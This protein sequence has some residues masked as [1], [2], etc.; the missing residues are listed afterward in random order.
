MV[1]SILTFCGGLALFVYGVD[2]LSSAMRVLVGI[3]LRLIMRTVVR[4]RG[5]GLIIGIIITFVLQSSSAATVLFVSMIQGGLLAFKDTIAM[6]LGAMV[7]TTLT[8][9][10]IA[11]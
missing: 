11:K 1:I 7:G 4:H 3:R 10:I 6:I 8:V 9:Q 5:A 2:Q